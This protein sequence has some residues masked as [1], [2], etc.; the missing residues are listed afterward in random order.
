MTPEILNEAEHIQEDMHRHVQAVMMEN[1]NLQYQDCVN[2]YLCMKLAEL[3]ISLK[4]QS[5]NP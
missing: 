1:Q 4:P 3:K 5:N 2:V